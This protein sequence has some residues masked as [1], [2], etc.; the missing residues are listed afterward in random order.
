VDFLLYRAYARYPRQHNRRPVLKKLVDSFYDKI[1]QPKKPSKLFEGMATSLGQKHMQIWMRD[2][3]EQRFVR[4]MN[5]DGGIEKAKGADYLYLVEQ[6]VGGNKLDYHSTQTTTSTITIEGNEARHRT[7]AL[8]EN[9]V[10]LPQPAF[11]MGDTGDL[12]QGNVHRPML[13]LYV[14][15]AGELT[16]PPKVVGTRRDSPPELA[17]WTDGNPAVHSERGKKVWSGTLEI[18]PLGKGSLSF[19]Y[20][21]PNVVRDVGGR[22]VYR[23]HVQHQPKVHPETLSLI[24]ELPDGATHVKARG[25]RKKNGQLTWNRPLE[26]DLVLEV[27]WR[28]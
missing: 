6:N 19:D 1:I 14:P 28:E 17:T 5:W 11:A 2:P 23:L 3:A 27:S 22:R 24:L 7:T 10:F 21:V 20:R 13:N 16:G 9:N 15:S 18:P 4:H 26:E 12:G 25:W 8:V